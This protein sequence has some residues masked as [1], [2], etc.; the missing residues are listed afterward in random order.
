M[1][2]TSRLVGTEDEHHLQNRVGLAFTSEKYEGQF[3]YSLVEECPLTELK[4]NSTDRKT[5]KFRKHH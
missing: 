1:M 5:Q 2:P 3:Q 4:I